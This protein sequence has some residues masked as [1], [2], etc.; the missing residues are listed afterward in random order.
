VPT[1]RRPQASRRAAPVPLT[2]EQ[3]VERRRLA[4]R[5]RRHRRLGTLAA[6]LTVL[7]VLAV[8]L[9]SS[10]GGQAQHL[11]PVSHA[12]VRKPDPPKLLPRGGRT[13]LPGQLVVAHYGIVGTSN[14]LGQT[15]DPEADAIAVQRTAGAYARLHQRVQPAF[16]LVTTI[17]SPDPGRDGT[18]SS[19]IGTPTLTRYL[20]AAHRH[21]LLL[22]LDF[23]PGRGE[24]LPEVRRYARFLLDPSVGV[25]LDPE[26]KLTSDQV[27]NQVIGS[28]SAAAINAVGSYLSQLIAAGRLPQKL[29]V[30]HEFRT[31]ELPDRQF[32]RF[33]PGLATVLQMD[34][35]GPVATKLHAYREVTTGAAGFHPGFKVFLRRTDDPVLLTP[36]EVLALHPPPQYISY[37]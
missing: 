19:P 4:R 3:R 9:L 33:W 30:V 5:R 6:G 1:R 34:G 13:V 18:Y 14:I 7:I 20:R 31:T 36:R 16:E 28:S 15:G 2:W 37:Q 11:R 21:K 25:A 17:A 35:L 8:V 22:I 12:T 24:F 27:P 32:I 29:F 26:W 10:G 23:Q